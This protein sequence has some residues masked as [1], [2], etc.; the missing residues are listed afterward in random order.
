MKKEEIK[1][2]GTEPIDADGSWIPPVARLA[3]AQLWLL[4]PHRYGHT[5]VALLHYLASLLPCPL[6]P[7]HYSWRGP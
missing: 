4:R 3:A 1:G 2:I 5:I 6:S 7:P